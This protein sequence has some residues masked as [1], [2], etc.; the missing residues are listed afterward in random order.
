VGRGS[1]AARTPASRG[2]PAAPGLRRILRAHCPGRGMP[3]RWPL[4]RGRRR[5]PA[6]HPVIEDAQPTRA[7]AA[8]DLVDRQ[9]AQQPERLVLS[10]GQHDAVGRALVIGIHCLLPDAADGLCGGLVRARAPAPGGARARRSLA[11]QAD[12]E[13]K[14]QRGHARDRADRNVVSYRSFLPSVGGIRVGRWAGG[15]CGEGTRTWSSP[16]CL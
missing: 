8:A 16:I 14:G 6:R 4:G 7:V 2:R 1:R 12:D 13:R 10:G 3:R 9:G 11:D 15:G 5:E